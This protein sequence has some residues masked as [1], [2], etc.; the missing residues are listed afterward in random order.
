MRSFLGFRVL[1][2][3]NLGKHLCRQVCLANLDAEEEAWLLFCLDSDI[4]KESS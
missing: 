3:E 1:G 4:L 2:W